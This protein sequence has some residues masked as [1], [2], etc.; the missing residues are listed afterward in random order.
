VAE[1]TRVAIDAGLSVILC[2]GETLEERKAGRCTEVIKKQLETVV[3]VIKTEA[4]W[5]CVS[6]Y[7]QIRL[8]SD[9]CVILQ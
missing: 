9:V 1:K 6:C 7:W 4:D 8:I 2:I 3:Q 5:R